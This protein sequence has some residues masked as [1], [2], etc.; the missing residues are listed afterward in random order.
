[1]ESGMSDLRIEIFV[2]I[3]HKGEGVEGR[4]SNRETEVRVC[5]LSGWGNWRMGD[6]WRFLVRLGQ[7]LSGG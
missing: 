4:L 7:S 2:D 6:P 1:M 3:F 5:E